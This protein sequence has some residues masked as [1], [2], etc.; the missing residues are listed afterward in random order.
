MKSVLIV[1]SFAAA[2]YSCNNHSN[3][4]TSGTDT[5]HHAGHDTTAANAQSGNA[6]KE[7]MD[8]MMQGMHSISPTDNNDIDFARMMVMHHQGAVEMSK[9]AI[10]KG[11]DSLLKAFAQTVITDQNK[12]IKFMEEFIAKSPKTPSP[13]AAVFQKAMNSSMMAM[14]KE[15]SLYNNIDKDFAAQMIPHHQSAVDMAKA[16]LAHGNTKELLALCNNIIN[17]QTKEISWLN[18]WLG[19]H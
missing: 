2:L 12:E 10:E 16:Y 6:I 17:A 15:T 4:Q 3:H 8:K 5:M 14:M 19:K 13:K 9:T 7:I 11:T 1:I 18:D